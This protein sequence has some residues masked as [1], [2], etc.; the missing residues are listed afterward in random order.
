MILSAT[1][2]RSRHSWL[3]WRPQHCRR[4]DQALF[5]LQGTH[6]R[7]GTACLGRSGHTGGQGHQAV[8]QGHSGCQHPPARRYVCPLAHR[9][10]SRSDG[11][12]EAAAAGFCR[13][14]PPAK[15]CVRLT[16]VCRVLSETVA[17]CGLLCPA[18]NACSSGHC[19]DHRLACIC[20]SGV[21]KQGSC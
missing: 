13:R 15:C 8:R 12:A 4:S 1:T 9:A 20:D 16:H 5:G 6:T 18:F 19:S 11:E 2:V 10:A 21:C 7:S 17:A 14:G 3:L